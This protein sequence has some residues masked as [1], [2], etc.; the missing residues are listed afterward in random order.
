LAAVAITLAVT[1]AM[2]P[3][4]QPLAPAGQSMRA[5]RPAGITE[6]FVGALRWPN[7][8]PS[9]MTFSGDAVVWSETT[10]KQSGLF[11]ADVRIQQ[12][13]LLRKAAKGI[14]RSSPV[15]AGEMLVWLE[16]RSGAKGGKLDVWMARPPSGASQLMIGQVPVR[17]LDA[18]GDLI[19]WLQRAAG[20]DDPDSP[21]DQVWTYDVASGRLRQIEAGVGPK[22]DIAVSRGVVAWSCREPDADDMTGVWIHDTVTGQTVH[23]VV[24]PVPSLDLSGHTLVWCSG[25]GDVYGLDLRTRTRF[26]IST[27]PGTQADVQIDGD[28]VAWWDGRA[29]RE[30]DSGAGREQVRG[31]VYAYDLSTGDEIPV[32]T[33]K[34]AQKDPRVSGDTIVWLDE[35]SGEWEIRGAVV[36]P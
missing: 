27:A 12:R 7:G 4:E 18:D 3:R 17:G 35:R 5:E 25:S 29:A 28:L 20:K 2:W 8:T 33:N 14:S 11:A 1:W 10:E 22:T 19:V 23:T 30:S 34:A 13:F 32:S 9:G 36:R 21:D 24:N 26:T 16:Q 31:D 6:F 15:L